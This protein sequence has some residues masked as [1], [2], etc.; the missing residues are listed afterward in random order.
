MLTRFGFDREE[1][2]QVEW[3]P[4]HETV[5]ASSADDR[6][7]MV[8]DLDRYFTPEIDGWNL[9]SIVICYFDFISLACVV[10]G[11]V[12]HSTIMSGR[13]CFQPATKWSIIVYCG[14]L[15]S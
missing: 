4:N 5:L 6:T 2:F 1:K 8:W 3:D 9:F 11:V 14:T 7:L 12:L 15:R 13:F 10:R